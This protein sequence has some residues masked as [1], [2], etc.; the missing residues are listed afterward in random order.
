MELKT[1]Y[2][3]AKRVEHFKNQ[4]LDYD[5][6]IYELQDSFRLEENYI[7]L[8]AITY[9]LHERK[10]NHINGIE[11]LDIPEGCTHYCFNPMAKNTPSWMFYK[12]LCNSEVIYIWWGSQWLFWQDYINK[13][14]EILP[15]VKIGEKPNFDSKVFKRHNQTA[16]EKIEKVAQEFYD[17]NA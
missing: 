5:E 17:E 16:Q 9:I 3:I 15:N 11:P 10:Q 7:D 14:N 1:I 6:D 4:N 8:M 12:V 13:I 2:E